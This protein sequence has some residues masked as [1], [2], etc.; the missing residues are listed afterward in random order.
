MHHLLPITGYRIG[1][2]TY[3]TDAKTISEA[4]FEKIK[5]TKILVINAL[6]KEPHISHFTLAEAIQFAQKVGAET[7]YLTH[8]SHNLGLHA[9][10]EK[11]LPANIRLAYDGLKIE[12]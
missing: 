12:L 8:I 9:V 1:D 7:T 11:D 6:Q 4:S 10:V 3:I 2:F 5:G